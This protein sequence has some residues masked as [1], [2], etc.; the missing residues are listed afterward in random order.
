MYP[1]L[2]TALY[3]LQSQSLMYCAVPK[4]ASK[5]LVSLMMYVVVRDIITHL[6][7]NSTNINI[8]K[9]RPEQLI[10]IPKLIDELQKV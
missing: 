5:T 8:K 7:N 4:V 3:P 2:N 1:W 10:D 9:I 6:D